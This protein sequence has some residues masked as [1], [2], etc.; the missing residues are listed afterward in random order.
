MA[1]RPQKVMFLLL[2]AKVAQATEK[3]GPETPESAVFAALCFVG[4]NLVSP[5][6]QDTAPRQP[7]MAPTAD[8]ESRKAARRPSRRLGSR[9]RAAVLK[10]KRGGGPECSRATIRL[11][12]D[13]WSALLG[14]N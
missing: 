10:V 7:K 6:A 2:C 12:I 11:Y 8:Q 14:A 4:A 9:T 13:M 5:G 1:L 3:G